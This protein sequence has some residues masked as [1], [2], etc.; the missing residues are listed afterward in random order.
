M[1]AEPPELWTAL[2]VV[3]GL[4]LVG[5]TRSYRLD[6]A[7]LLAG[8]DAVEL[9]GQRPPAV[10]GRR[11]RLRKRFGLDPPPLLRADIGAANAL[12]IGGPR[13]GVFVFERRLLCLLTIDELEG[14]LAHELAHLE[15]RD[16]FVQTLAVSSMQTLAGLLS[17]VLVPVTLVLVGIAH[18]AA[19][20]AGPPHRAPNVAAM[21]SLGVSSA[22]ARS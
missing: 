11:D 8:I 5:G 20:V 18:G 1:L 12:S 9:P 17:V 13:G 21:A 16:G 15:S 3:A 6:S 2:L 10:Y 22:S 7:Q 19:W 4:T 14:I